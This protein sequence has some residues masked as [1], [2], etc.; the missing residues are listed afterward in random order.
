M[1]R[2]RRFVTDTVVEAA[3]EQFRD[4]SYA[5]TSTEELCARTGLSR[6]SL[7]NAF[8]SKSELFQVALQRYD[9]ARRSTSQQYLDA[10]RTGRE[11]VEQLLRDTIRIQ[12]ETPD[13]RI[14]MVLAASVEIGRQDAAIAELAR[15]NLAGFAAVLTRL[16]ERGQRDGS[17][18]CRLPAA[19]L[20]GMLHAMTNGLQ[21]LGRVSTDDAAL[22]TT[23][24]TALALL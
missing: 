15:R 23:I 8:G 10:E 21:V 7:Y 22:Q 19:D 9:E 18:S 2:P 24:D 4:G 14:C 12:F 13:H 3:I 16:I 5:A 20:A 11:L 6:S 17:I 1:G